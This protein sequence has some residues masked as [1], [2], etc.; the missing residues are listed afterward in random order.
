MSTLT[1]IGPLPERESLHLDSG[2]PR[3][4]NR[5]YL[6]VGGKVGTPNVSLKEWYAPD[7]NGT[8]SDSLVNLQ[9]SQ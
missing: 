2:L 4:N 7:N 1:T 8:R 6:G 3:V 5:D 9:E